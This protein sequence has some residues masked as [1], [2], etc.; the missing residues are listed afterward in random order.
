MKGIVNLMTV[1]INLQ[2]ENSNLNS[3]ITNLHNENPHLKAAISQQSSHVTN[4]FVFQPKA[5]VKHS[6]PGAKKHDEDQSR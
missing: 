3:V 1:I 4:F 6:R 5:Y 2:R